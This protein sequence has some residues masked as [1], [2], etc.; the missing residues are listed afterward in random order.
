M[1]LYLVTAVQLGEKKIC[2]SVKGWGLGWERSSDEH[3][4]RILL[5]YVPV[6]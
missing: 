3:Q 5:V 6:Q 1:G 4:H 2:L